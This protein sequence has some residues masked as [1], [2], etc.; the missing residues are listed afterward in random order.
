MD[1]SSGFPIKNASSN[2]TVAASERLKSSAPEYREVTK[3]HGPELEPSCGLRIPGSAQVEA[4]PCN[5]LIWPVPRVKRRS[6]PCEPR[7]VSQVSAVPQPARERESEEAT[8][9]II[10]SGPPMDGNLWDGDK[11]P[12]RLILLLLRAAGLWTGTSARSDSAFARFRSVFAL[13]RAAD[14]FP[15]TFAR[16]GRTN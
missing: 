5:V 2:G 12:G 6:P 9:R 1:Y 4:A 11:S 3:L 14:T 10:I 7:T 13:S 15:Y 16:Q 8:G